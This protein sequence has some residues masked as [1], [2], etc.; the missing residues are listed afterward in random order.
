MR[1]LVTVVGVS[2]LAAAV[3]ARAPI[4]HPLPPASSAI[5][6]PR[7]IFGD[8]N[9]GEGLKVVQLGKQ[10]ELRSLSWSLDQ[11][12]SQHKIMNESIP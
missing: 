6:L 9:Q 3:L 8:R 4:I 5:E 10:I 1:R 11:D 2:P 7:G 12:K